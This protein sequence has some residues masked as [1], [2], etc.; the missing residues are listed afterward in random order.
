VREVLS[1]QQQTERGKKKSLEVERKKSG[2]TPTGFSQSKKD[3][4]NLILD[5]QGKVSS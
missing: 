4:K 5:L 2:D 1:G 3:P